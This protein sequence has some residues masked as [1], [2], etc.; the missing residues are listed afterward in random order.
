MVKVKKKLH[1]IPFKSVVKERTTRLGTL[2]L[3]KQ[4]SAIIFA[5][6]LNGKNTVIIFTYW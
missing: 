6:L 3:K 2:S 4:V 5:D 1:R